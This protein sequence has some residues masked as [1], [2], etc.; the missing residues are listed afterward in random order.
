MEPPV[1]SLLEYFC[2]ASMPAWY[3]IDVE[4]ARE[5]ARKRIKAWFERLDDQSQRSS[6]SREAMPRETPA[7][8]HHAP[9]GVTRLGYTLASPRDYFRPR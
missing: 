2:G 1:K 5:R 3:Y 7:V 9:R 4:K 6:S 8:S